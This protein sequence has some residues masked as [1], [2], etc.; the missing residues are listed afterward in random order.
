MAD[1]LTILTDPVDEDIYEL[2]TGDSGRE[3]E[4][5][6]GT[7]DEAIDALEAGIRQ[8]EGISGVHDL[9]VWS[10][11]PGEDVVTVHVVLCDGSQ[12]AD[13][14]AGVRGVIVAE[15]PHAHVTVQP[16]P[17]HAAC[18]SSSAA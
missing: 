15:L 3:I 12:A 5:T 11:R 16:E 2:A 6:P 13:V 7:L 8:V 18:G 9:H 10:L 4:R 14:S 1:P 17:E